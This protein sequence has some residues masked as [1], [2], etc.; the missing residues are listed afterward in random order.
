MKIHIENGK[1][2]SH[3]SQQDSWE[4]INSYFDKND[5]VRQQTDSYDEFIN[6]TIQEIIEDSKPIIVISEP[7]MDKEEKEICTKVEIKFGQIYVIP[8]IHTETNGS[9]Q[10]ILPSDCRLRHLTYSCGLQLEVF[11]KVS[12]INNNTHQEYIQYE[13]MNQTQIGKIPMMVRS[14]LCTL[15]KEIKE[16]GIDISQTGECV[17]DQGGYFI[18]NGRERVLVAQ[19][20][21]ATNHVLC[22]KNKSK[23]WQA[24]VR[25]KIETTN[26]PIASCSVFYQKSK[27]GSSISGK[28]FRVLIPYVKQ[29]IP[30]IIMFRALGYVPDRSILE[31]I[32]YDFVDKQMLEILRPSLDEAKLIRNSDL[33]LDYIGRRGVVAGTPKSERIKWAKN[34]LQKETL[35]HMGIGKFCETQKAFFLGYMTN[36]LCQCILGRREPDD[37]DNFGNK[38]LDIA[39]PLLANLFRLHWL[40]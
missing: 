16:N 38:R 17:F 21:M 12:Y 9:S 6:N 32:C 20:R 30:I 3:I 14:E 26:K 31:L 24:E 2:K 15:T 25:S 34:I 40:R 39:G 28:V 36:K 27:L 1:D 29:E 33:A 11:R 18:I 22:T 4:V 7:W 19:E 35:G 13:D 37:R 10:P 23:P 8:P 5:L